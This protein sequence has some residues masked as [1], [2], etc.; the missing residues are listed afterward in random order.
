MHF[1]MQPKAKWVINK[2]GNR[3]H[4]RSECEKHF[5]LATTSCEAAWD[6][7]QRKNLV[8]MG[9]K[10]SSQWNVSS[11]RK[12]TR[13]A[14][15]SVCENTRD[16]NRVKGI[17]SQMQENEVIFDSKFLMWKSRRAWFNAIFPTRKNSK[18]EKKLNLGLKWNKREEKS[19]FSSWTLNVNHDVWENRLVKL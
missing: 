19:F 8:W 5:H 4:E 12:K 1:R 15:F 17:H 14:L 6:L 2:I 10:A 9:S 11:N 18:T 3:K 13:R 7:S 16:D